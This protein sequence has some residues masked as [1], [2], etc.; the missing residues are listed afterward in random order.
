MGNST[1]KEKVR[2]LLEAM[3]TALLFTL[4]SIVYGG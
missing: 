2:L 4:Q 1:L 3:L